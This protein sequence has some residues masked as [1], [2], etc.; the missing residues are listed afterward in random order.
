MVRSCDGDRDVES[1]CLLE[2]ETS[3]IRAS[4]TT[5]K[6]I[7]SKGD[8]PETS[9]SDI[10]RGILDN[11]GSLLDLDAY[12]FVM[13]VLECFPHLSTKLLRHFAKGGEKDGPRHEFGYLRQ[14]LGPHGNDDDDKADTIKELIDRSKI[15][16]GVLYFNPFFQTFN[17]LMFS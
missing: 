16:V 1:Y 4:E 11:A 12:A 6:S 13:I 9:K 2:F 15:T 7:K 14:L 17:N 5:D 8:Y 10:D 3:E